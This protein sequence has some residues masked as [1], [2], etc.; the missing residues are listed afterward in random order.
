MPRKDWDEIDSE[1]GEESRGR[2]ISL[3]L[4]TRGMVLGKENK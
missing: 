2:F 4:R 3:L 1:R